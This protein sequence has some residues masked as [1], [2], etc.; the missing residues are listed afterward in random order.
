MYSGC[1]IVNTQK[2]NVVNDSF[3]K[4]P[5]Q[6]DIGENNYYTDDLKNHLESIWFTYIGTFKVDEIYQYKGNGRNY[7]VG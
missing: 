6:S 4:A 2:I 1:T 3:Q 5:D 7:H